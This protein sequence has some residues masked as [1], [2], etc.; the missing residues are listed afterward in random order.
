M[1][2]GATARYGAYEAIEVAV[3]ESIALITLGAD[4]DRAN[5]TTAMTPELT[6]CFRGMRDDPDIRAIVITGRG[7]RFSSGG[8]IG[9]MRERA[10]RMADPRGN[11]A[12]VRRLPVDRGT[13][14]MTAMLDLDV[15]VI[16]AVNGHAV[17]AGLRIALLADIMVVA[18]EAKLGDT[19]VLRG[20]VAPQAY[21]LALAA[22][23]PRAKSML[24]SG[25]LISGAQAVQI[26][27]ADRALPAQDVLSSALAQA[28]ELAAL[29]PL[30]IRWTKR[31]LNNQIRQAVHAHATEGYGLES[32]T[33]LSRD[34]A[35]AVAAFLEKRD[36]AGYEGR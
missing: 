8:D 30:A 23:M 22:G 33:M 15:P 24:L 28:R 26:G 11:P 14:F 2:D 1:T 12:W 10:E 20:L 5:P 25:K 16:A 21:L 27:L 29:P 3:S 9:T 32:L 7:R 4:P 35:E 36:P 34:H 13:D 17:G 31:I 18:E 6:A 19:H